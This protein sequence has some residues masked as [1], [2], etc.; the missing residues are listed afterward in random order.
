LRMPASKKILINVNPMNDSMKKLSGKNMYVVTSSSD[1]LIPSPELIAEY[2]KVV[3]GS[4]ERILRMAEEQ[5]RHRTYIEIR[6]LK[7][8]EKTR[9]LRQKLRTTLAS[10]CQGAGSVLDIYPVSYTLPKVRK[11]SKR[12]ES[13]EKHIRSYWHR[14]GNDIRHAI[15][16][17]GNGRR[18]RNNISS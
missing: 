12:H 7:N 6:A 1:S 16:K 9:Q 3:R 8:E 2:E 14:T 13:T 5:A 15:E 17:Y 18:Q 4:G 11:Q 10:I